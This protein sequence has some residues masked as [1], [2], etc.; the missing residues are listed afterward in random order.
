MA[1]ALQTRSVND[2]H[3]LAARVL[4]PHRSRREVNQALENEDIFNLALASPGVY[5]ALLPEKTMRIRNVLNVPSENQF[6]AIRPVVAFAGVWPGRDGI[7][8][9]G[10]LTSLCDLVR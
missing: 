7:M 3:A 1:E 4:V 5:I 6:R 8:V 9:K 10:V 2:V